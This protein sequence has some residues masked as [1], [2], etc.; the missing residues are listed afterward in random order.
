LPQ[1][2]KQDQQPEN[3]PL[4]GQ[5]R[6]GRTAQARGGEKG[7]QGAGGAKRWQL[8]NLDYEAS[9]IATHVCTNAG[10]IV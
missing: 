4:S 6:D 2:W 1:K 8:T 10:W 3:F 9:T 5:E 7:V